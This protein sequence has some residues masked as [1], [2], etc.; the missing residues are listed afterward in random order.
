MTVPLPAITIWQPYASLIATGAKIYETRDYPPPAHHIGKRIAIH[1]AKSTEDLR[2]LQD[3]LI[4][5]LRADHPD[6]QCDA[7]VTALKNAGFS[8]LVDM[9]RGAVVC[10]AVLAAAYRC[11][12]VDNT[13]KVFVTRWLPGNSDP[14][15]IQSDPFGNYSPNRWAWLLKDVQ[16]LA[17]P[18]P[19]RGK[20]GWWSWSPNLQSDSALLSQRRPSAPG[21]SPELFLE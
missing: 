4:S 18:A 21:G 8:K 5:G 7:I 1:A 19:A 13:G 2:F 9:P 15:F 11:G 17:A 12:A 14:L 6:A 20:Q 3:Y 16:P 10:T